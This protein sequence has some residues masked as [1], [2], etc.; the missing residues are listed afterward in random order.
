MS[1][2]AKGVRESLEKLVHGGDVDSYDSAAG[3]SLQ[4]CTMQ[5]WLSKNSQNMNLNN[6][7]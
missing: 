1:F 7:H 4:S 5:N 2:F 6:Q 3:G